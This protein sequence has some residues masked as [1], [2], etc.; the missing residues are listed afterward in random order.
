M[1]NFWGRFLLF[2]YPQNTAKLLSFYFVTAHRKNDVLWLFGSITSWRFSAIIY[3]T[4]WRNSWQILWVRIKRQL[5]PYLQ[6]NS[7]WRTPCIEVQLPNYGRRSKLLTG[8]ICHK[9]WHIGSISWIWDTMTEIL[10]Q[11]FI[12]VCITLP[13]TG[14]QIIIITN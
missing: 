8:T 7:F 14:S 5:L 13:I 2:Y 1:P 4:F 11:F 3:L 6:K 10:Q 9:P 12:H